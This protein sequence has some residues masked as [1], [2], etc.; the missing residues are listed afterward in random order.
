MSSP[1]HHHLYGVYRLLT[2][3][4]L[5]APPL[6]PLRALIGQCFPQTEL[7]CS[8]L[9]LRLMDLHREQ[10]A[11]KSLLEEEESRQDQ[12]SDGGKSSIKLH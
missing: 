6:S 8:R 12:I 1:I 10:T 4:T 5:V 9:K 11:V 3:V 7:N 2:V